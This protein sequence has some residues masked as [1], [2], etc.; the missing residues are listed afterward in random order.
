[1]GCTPTQGRQLGIYLENLGTIVALWQSTMAS[2][3]IRTNVGLNW[4]KKTCVPSGNLTSYW[5]WPFIVDLPIKNGP[6]VIF[7]SYVSLPEG[8]SYWML[9]CHVWLP[10]GRRA[11]WSTVW[12]FKI[13]WEPDFFFS[14]LLLAFCIFLNPSHFEVPTLVKKRASQMRTLMDDDNGR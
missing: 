10:E 8:K 9:H 12:K 13:G 1:M 3:E 5:T 4:K 6:M 11:E 7:H 2:W 14:I